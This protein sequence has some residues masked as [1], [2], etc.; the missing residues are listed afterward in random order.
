MNSSLDS[1]PSSSL[2]RPGGALLGV[3]LA[4]GAWLGGAVRHAAWRLIR[5]EAAGAGG[6]SSMLNNGRNEGPPDL[7]ELWRDLNRKLSGLF[8]GRRGRGDPGGGPNFQPDM[9]NAGLGAGLIAGVIAL[10]WLVSGFFIV[11]EGEQ[12]VVLTFGKFSKTV[13]AGFN[14][15]Y[16]FP[17]QQHEIVRVTQTRSV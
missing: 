9:R 12:A 2:N 11:Q 10:I 3:V 4:A 13:D 1:K 8:G 15:R 7:D 5:R 14:W 17:F 16:P 6:G